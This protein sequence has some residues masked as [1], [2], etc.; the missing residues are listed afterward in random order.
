MNT[1]E[2]FDSF[3]AS[4]A[5]PS[6]KS[7][8]GRGGR[9]GELSDHGMADKVAGLERAI[10]SLVVLVASLQGQLDDARR[11]ESMTAALRGATRGNFWHR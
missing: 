6:E 9:D 5:S 2:F 10:A 11:P 1:E 3:F 4:D 8:R 7:N